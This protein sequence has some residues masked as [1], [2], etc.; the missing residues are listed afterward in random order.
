MYDVFHFSTALPYLMAKSKS[1][2]TS[3]D[4]I[5]F[6]ILWIFTVIVLVGFGTFGLNPQLLAQFPS[7]AGFYPYSFLIFSRGHVIL[8]FAVLAL[9]L[10]PR[11]GIKWLPALILASAISLGMELLGTKTG[12]P[13]SGYAYTGLLGYKVANLVPVLIPFSWFMMAF[14]SYVLARCVIKNRYVQWIIGSFL[15][16][17]WD[18]TLD[19]AMS[20]L[21]NYWVWDQPGPYY[22]MPLVN[23]LGWF[24]TGILIMIAFD[25]SHAGK[26]ADK[27]PASVMEFYYFTVVV[28]SL[29]MTLLAGYLLAV[30]LT[31]V[32]I[33]ALRFMIHQ[34]QSLLAN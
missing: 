30:S 20:E 3:S 28:L 1:A 15:L 25:Y 7:S 4:R 34:H 29:G 17:A 21:S 2:F 31:L 10:I 9:I 12:F 32:V 5:G 23:L 19:P 16:T 14:P 26:I 6:T 11:V 8:A 33:A 13:F 24:G 22:G 18:L 27:I